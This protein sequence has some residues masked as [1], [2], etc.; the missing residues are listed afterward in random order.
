MPDSD[1][2]AAS[3]TALCVG[4]S[5][6]AALEA[7]GGMLEVIEGFEHAPYRLAGGQIVWIGTR[8]PVQH[9]RAVLLAS[10][11]GCDAR[12]V[13]LAR[14][15]PAA[16]SGPRLR[17]GDAASQQLAMAA[18]ILLQGLDAL[19]PAKG[20]GPAL[21]GA[22]LDFP[23]DAV[24]GKAQAF[25]RACGRGDWA[26]ACD[27]GRGL[28]GVGAGLTPSGDD[29]VGGVLFALRLGARGGRAREVAHFAR[30]LCGAARERT[31]LISA[32]LLEDVAELRGYSPVDDLGFAALDGSAARVTGAARKLVALGHS[33]GWD[34]L[35]GFIAGARASL[36]P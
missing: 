10:A 23:L 9:P 2:S 29:F 21:R 22:A 6:R 33:S 7:C 28:L 19:G 35:A 17:A 26:G 3:A 30:R 5:A 1:V 18:D 20:F 27:S 15:W 4:D 14:P 11:T 13:R 25:A 24:R 34:L 12:R 8:A 32:T 16:R 36:A 31:H